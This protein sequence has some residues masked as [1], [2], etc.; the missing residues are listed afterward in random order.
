MRRPFISDTE[1]ELVHG[2]ENIRRG[3]NDSEANGLS[4]AIGDAWDERSDW[5][6]KEG[7]K[8]LHGWCYETSRV[9]QE[10]LRARGP[11]STIL[12]GEIEVATDDFLVMGRISFAGSNYSSSSTSLRGGSLATLME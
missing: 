4:A 9:L 8:S 10:R 1:C 2:V 3:P 5:M 11:N 7:V 6:R 12:E